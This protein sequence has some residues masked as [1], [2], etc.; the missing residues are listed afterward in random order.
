MPTSANVHQ[1]SI[2]EFLEREGFSTVDEYLDETGW[3]MSIVPAL[4]SEG[5]EVEP[6]GSCEHG[7]PSLLIVLGVI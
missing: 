2:V 6:D 3:D 5:C 1:I 7:C 4:C